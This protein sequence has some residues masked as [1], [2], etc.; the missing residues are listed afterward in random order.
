MERN[1]I[2]KIVSPVVLAACLTAC[3]AGGGGVRA[4]KKN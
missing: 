4:E 2:W 1:R 3:G